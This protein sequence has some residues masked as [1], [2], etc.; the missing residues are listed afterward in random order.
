M[1]VLSCPSTLFIMVLRVVA[2]ICRVTLA[3]DR[4]AKLFLSLEE[5]IVRSFKTFNVSSWNEEF[6]ELKTEP[7]DALTSSKY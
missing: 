4:F 5:L 3:S 6:A 2:K 7:E 1:M